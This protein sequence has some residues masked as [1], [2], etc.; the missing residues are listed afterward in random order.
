MVDHSY[1]Y[2]GFIKKAGGKFR[3]T[4]LIRRRMRE[5]QRGMAPLVEKKGSLLE[6]ALAEFQEGKIWLAVG[7][8]A[9]ALRAERETTRKGDLKP[10]ASRSPPPPALPPPPGKPKG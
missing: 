8:E 2:D 1:D 7:P 4:T 5:L 6:T 10:P 9:D 3:F